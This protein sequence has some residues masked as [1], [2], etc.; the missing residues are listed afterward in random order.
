MG[1]R[2]DRRD[3]LEMNEMMRVA[4]AEHMNALRAVQ[5]NPS[6]PNVWDRDLKA[7]KEAGLIRFHGWPS[8]HWQI[9]PAGQDY[10]AAIEDA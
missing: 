2:T 10:L 7:A 9:T 4:M 8:G 1:W 6:V 3:Y 5:R